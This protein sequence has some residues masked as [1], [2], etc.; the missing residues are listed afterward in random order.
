MQLKTHASSALIVMLL[1]D[2]YMQKNTAGYSSEY[3]LRLMLFVVAF[4][5]QYFIDTV[6]HTVKR[7][8]DRTYYTRN[9]WHSLPAVLALGIAVGIPFAILSGIY[10]VAL[11]PVL[12]LLIHLL[13]D[14][15]TEGGV[16]IGKRKMRVAK[17]KYD[18]P[19]INR[20]AIIVLLIPAF[21]YFPIMENSFNF[22]LASAVYLYSAYALLTV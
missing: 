9:K 3:L 8:K 1:F 16:Y 2:A 13:E 20:L 22:I 15:I 12:A 11:A 19:L 4:L 21:I 6:G 17:I 7:Y 18:N 10:I 14:F 5:L